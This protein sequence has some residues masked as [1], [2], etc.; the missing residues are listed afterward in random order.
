MESSYLVMLS[1]VIVGKSHKI[2]CMGNIKKPI[3]TTSK[4][5]MIDPYIRRIENGNSIS[6][7][8]KPMPEMVRGAPDQPGLPGLAVMD[9][10]P[11]DY[12]VVHALDSNAGPVRYLDS[13]PSTV[14][15][16][17]TIHYQLVLKRNAHVPFE[18]NP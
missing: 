10:K 12:H 7:A 2:R 18:Y 5:A 14:N 11:M 16:L 8:T 4:V 9:A 1:K 3:R 6:V 13:G 15:S 17:I